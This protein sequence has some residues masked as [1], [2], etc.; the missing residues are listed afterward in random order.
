MATAHLQENVEDYVQGKINASTK[1]VLFIKWVG[2][3]WEG[4]STKKDVIIRSFKK[5]G[6][7]VGIDGLK[8]LRSTFLG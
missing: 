4:I 7:S 6:I 8:I 2:Q 3:A 5:C 1:R